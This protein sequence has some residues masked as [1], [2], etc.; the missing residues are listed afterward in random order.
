ME[1]FPEI[2]F[3]HPYWYRDIPE[4][5]EDEYSLESD[6]EEEEEAEECR[7]KPVGIEVEGK[8]TASHDARKRKEGPR[9]KE[10][11]A[12][13]KKA[14]VPS[15][16]DWWKNDGALNYEGGRH[17]RKEVYARYV[18]FGSLETP[19]KPVA[20]WRTLNASGVVEKLHGK[21]KNPSE[22]S[23]TDRV[24]FKSKQ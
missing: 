18:A 1:E 22:G 5:E 19:C 7:N 11:K 23:E 2:P 6:G 17:D 16:L 9:V 12:P 20:F 10:P 3:R 15:V 24:T 21:V 4:P 8:T 14:K 13:R